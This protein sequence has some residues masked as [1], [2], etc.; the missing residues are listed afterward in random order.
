M[1]IACLECD[2]IGSFDNCNINLSPKKSYLVKYGGEWY[3]GTFTKQWYGWNFNGVF[4]A[5]CQMDYPGWQAIYEIVQ[6]KKK[7]CPKKK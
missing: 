6:R 3:A 7:C 2:R 1:S 5:G 4:D